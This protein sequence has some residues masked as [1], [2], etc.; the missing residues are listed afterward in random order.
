MPQRRGVKVDELDLAGPHERVRHRLGRPHA[1]DPGD[2]LAQRFDVADVE[3]GV[4]VDAACQQFLDILP[5][6]GVAIAG[7]VRVGEL[8]HHGQLRTSAENRPNVK[9]SEARIPVGDRARRNHFEV[10]E[11]GS[12]LGP[13]VPLPL[14]H[15]GVD[16][17]APPG[18]CIPQH[19][20]GL[21]HPGG[22]P[23]VGAQLS[24]TC[25][26]VRVLHRYQRYPLET[27]VPTVSATSTTGTV[28]TLPQ[29]RQWKAAGEQ[30]EATEIT[31]QT[32]DASSAGTDE[33]VS[34]AAQAGTGAAGEVEAAG[35]FRIYLGAAPGVGKTYAMLS[36]GHR[37]LGRGAD[38]VAGFVESYGRPQTEAL[39][40][41]LEVIP[42]KAVDYRGTRLEEM[43][44]DAVLRRRPGVALIDE[45]AHTNVT[46]SGT[47]L[48]RWQDI[49]D[50]LSAGIDVVTTVNIQHLESIADE[51]ERM[52]ETRVRERVPDS[53]VRE[54][55]QIE[56]IDSSPE[57]LRRRMLH[58]NI[59]PQDRVLEALTH[60]FRTD[61]LIALRE[62]ALRFVADESD[63]ELIEHLQRRRSP[64][65]WETTERIMVAVSAVRGTDMLLRRAAR[66]ASR[67]RG[68]LDVVHV[69]AGDTG[70]PGDRRPTD[71]LRQ[72]A[73]DLGARW[74]EI[75]DDDPARAIIDFARQH[76]ITQIVI[77]SIQRSGW[78]ITDGGPI[79]RHV[80][81][82]A[83]EYGVDV[84]IIGRPEKPPAEA[85]DSSAAKES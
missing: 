72:L 78:H 83:G 61:N 66:I 52:T 24:P 18:A 79:L 46:G 31:G 50:I 69:I 15:H 35:H 8:I 39:V 55:G 47:N 68:E 11:L 42:R 26:R 14:G 3:S 80:I 70:L 10:V 85:L 20:I 29:L 59:Y 57:Q 23:E 25:Q 48:K 51:V 22:N 7:E 84:H 77:G 16:A 13:P 34:D 1:G 5:P 4:D 60:F 74:H 6:F 53:F 27:A 45:L 75:Q 21:P 76:Q 81:H 58:G 54:A 12:G 41:G 33:E 73:A 62:L 32:R 63:E 40:D 17:G 71:G 67:V 2:G 19:R 28:E 64:V 37:R 43:D 9:L 44:L 30:R 56:L 38:V 65:L 82:E 49:R 36:E